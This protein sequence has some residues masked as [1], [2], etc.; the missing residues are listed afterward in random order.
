MNTLRLPFRPSSSSIYQCLR[1]ASTSK[2]IHRPVPSPTPFVPDHTTFLKLI[3]RELSQHAA[4]IPSWEALFTL[5]SEQLRQLGVESARSRKYLLRWREKFRNGEYG[6]GG[7]LE[8]VENGVGE[9]RCIE[10]PIPPE[11]KTPNTSVA[12]ATSTPGTRKIAVNVPMGAEQPTV[13]LDRAK[14]VNFTKIR[15]AHTICGPFLEI[16][17]GSGGW[18]AKIEAKEGIWETRKGKKVD[19]GER[20]KAEVRAKRRAEERRTTRA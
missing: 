10:V 18:A 17:K 6:I 4:K 7:D 14:P 8:H 2:S 3:G 5:S 1:Y 12:T 20:R 19:G 15:R 13:P 9:M 11:W 16:V